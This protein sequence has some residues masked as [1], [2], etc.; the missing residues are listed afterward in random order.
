MSNQNKNRIYGLDVYRAIAIIIVVMGHGILVNPQISPPFPV[1]DGVELFFVLSG[2]LIG[3]ILIRTLEK[4]NVFNFRSVLYFWK[5]RWFRTLP[6]YYLILFVNYMLVSS[7][8]INGDIDQFGWSFIFFTQ[9]LYTSFY[10]FFWESWSLSVE[11]WFYIILPLFILISYRFL[12]IKHALMTTIACLILVPLIYRI[13]QSDLQVDSYN[14]DVEFRKVVIMRMDTIVYGV[15]AAYI[16]Y[17]HGAIWKKSRFICFVMGILIIYTSIYLPKESNDF[18]TK[19]FNFVLVSIGAMLLLPYADSV[20]SYRVRVVGKFITH[21][22]KISYSMYLVNLALVAQ[23][24]MKN[25]KPEN[26]SDQM[27]M[28]VVFWAVTIG[29]STVLYYCF[30]RPIM[31]LRDRF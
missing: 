1:I 6:N 8:L 17:Y 21:I 7:E 25:F 4:D 9:N 27:V 2:F 13:S 23:V 18:F 28:Y 20:K 16:K 3:S 19:T 14:F 30:E 22:S 24:I 11:E 10:G 29:I 12:S 5:R 31:K 26:S 15:L